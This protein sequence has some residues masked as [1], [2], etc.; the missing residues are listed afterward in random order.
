MVLI[1]LEEVMRGIFDETEDR[2]LDLDKIKKIFG[3]ATI[4]IY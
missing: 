3:L 4:F 2:L 1:Q